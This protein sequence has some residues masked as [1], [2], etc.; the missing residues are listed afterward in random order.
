MKIKEN[1]NKIVYFINIPNRNGNRKS[2]SVS[3]IYYNGNLLIFKV[4]K[5]KLELKS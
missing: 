3:N 2:F 5:L 4:P 1:Y